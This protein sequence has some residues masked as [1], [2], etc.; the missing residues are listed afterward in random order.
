MPDSDRSESSSFALHRIPNGL[1]VL[2]TVALLLQGPVGAFE[3]LWGFTSNLVSSLLGGEELFVEVFCQTAPLVFAAATIAVLCRSRRYAVADPRLWLVSS[4]MV[5]AAAWVGGELRSRTAYSTDQ[6]DSRVAGRPVSLRSDMRIMSATRSSMIPDQS[7]E[8]PETITV[9]EAVRQLSDFQSPA[10]DGGHH[11]WAERVPRVALIPETGTVPGILAR[12]VNQ[13]LGYLV[14]YRPRLFLA[15]I[16]LGAYV[17][18]SWQPQVE[19]LRCWFR[20]LTGKS[21]LESH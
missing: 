14:V 18:W 21:A 3:T 11:R 7:R 17:G 15:A 12:A 16:L 2:L 6:A 8:T 9:G 4:T 5:L 10:T 20:S 19:S 13:I 1:V